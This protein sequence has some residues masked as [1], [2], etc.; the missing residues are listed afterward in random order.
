MGGG[1]CRRAPSEKC[2]AAPDSNAHTLASSVTGGAK[3][4]A[5]GLTNPPRLMLPSVN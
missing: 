2:A 1:R 5:E 4:R 3:D